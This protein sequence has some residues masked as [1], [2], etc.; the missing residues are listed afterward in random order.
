MQT[1]ITISSEMDAE[2]G[3]Q[4]PWIVISK[5]AVQGEFLGQTVH[6]PRSCNVLLPKRCPFG[7]FLRAYS[8]G[9]KDV[10]PFFQLLST[11]SI[12]LPAMTK[13]SSSRLAQVFQKSIRN[14]KSPR[15]RLCDYSAFG[16]SATGAAG[17][18][19]GAAGATGAATGAFLLFLKMIFFF[20]ALMTPSLIRKL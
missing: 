4:I 16:A 1:W 3:G 5:D 6:F 12:G 14:K 11:S 18:G 9:L 2:L 8:T 19:A 15:R 10:S 13:T 7:V 17:A 20:S